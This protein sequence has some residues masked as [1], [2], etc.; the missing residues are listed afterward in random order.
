MTLN[1]QTN[2][3]RDIDYWIA[4]W[5]KGDHRASL[6]TQSAYRRDLGE[7]VQIVGKTYDSVEIADIMEYQSSLSA[8]SY[9][10]KTVARKLASVRS[11]YRF[12]N[13]RGVT[14]LNLER[15]ESSK[16]RQALDKNKLLTE[17]EV[18][19]IIEAARPYQVHYVFARFL[20]LTAVRV[21]EALALRWR[22]ITLLDGGAEAHIVGKGQHRRDV[23]VPPLLW[24]DLASLRGDSGENGLLFPSLD[25]QKAWRLVRQLAKAAQIGDDKKVSPHSFRHAHISHALKNGATL[26]ELRDQAGHANISTTSLYIH[27]NT[28]RATATRLKIQ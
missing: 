2:N 12:L 24:A 18:E 13:R 15:L 8:R 28:D 26:A 1:Y 9:K 20:Y 7:F 22:D 27:A 10:P 3:L 19:A 23:F 17:R 5:F 6:H 21:S 14:K 25:R 4:E 16:V 11:F